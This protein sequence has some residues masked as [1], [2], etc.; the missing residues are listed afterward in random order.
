MQKFS[1]PTDTNKISLNMS[2]SGLKLVEGSLTP[3]Q[4]ALLS[5][6]NAVNVI[7]VEAALSDVESIFVCQLNGLRTSSSKCECSFF[8]FLRNSLLFFAGKLER[9][10]D[11]C[12]KIV[13]EG[14]TVLA[15]KSGSC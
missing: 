5:N 2:G 13:L 4:I 3:Q 8:K 14:V 15:A 7:T 6:R 12:S 10:R 1:R 11:I 9:A